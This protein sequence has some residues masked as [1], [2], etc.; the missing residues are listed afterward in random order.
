MAADR[1]ERERDSASRAV[2]VAED[3]AWRYRRERD[4]ARADA[5]E[6]RS[7]LYRA[8]TSWPYQPPEVVGPEREAMLARL[9]AM[10]EDCGDDD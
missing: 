6:L 9:K 8:L 1:T 4:E 7:M 2:V 10:R 5:E 3:E